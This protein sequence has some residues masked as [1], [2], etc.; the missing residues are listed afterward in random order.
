M[1]RC[2]MLDSPTDR[3][4]L[5]EEGCNKWT[6]KSMLGVVCKLVLS[7]AVYGI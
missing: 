6:T 1:Q 4:D 3:I 5:I 2:D 7:S